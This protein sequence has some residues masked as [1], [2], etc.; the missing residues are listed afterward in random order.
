MTFDEITLVSSLTIVAS[1]TI[2]LIGFPQQAI[3]LY[4]AKNVGN[5]SFFLF[6]S[7]FISYI[8]WTY[9]GYLKKDW[10][11]IWGQSVGILTSGIVLFL[12]WRYRKNTR[13]DFK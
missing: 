1:Y 4:R 8:L 11:I 13:E 5:L 10:V 6:L 2:K 7:S 3:K 12:L 9:Y